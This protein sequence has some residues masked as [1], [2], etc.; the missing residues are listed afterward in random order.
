MA[1]GLQLLTFVI[2]LVAGVLAFKAAR[3]DVR[4]SMDHFI[5]DLRRQSRWASWAAGGAALA[6]MLEPIAYFVARSPSIFP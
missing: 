3:V 2:A 1:D 5:S 6:A 4:D